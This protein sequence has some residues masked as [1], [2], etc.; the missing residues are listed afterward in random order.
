MEFVHLLQKNHQFTFCYIVESLTHCLTEV[1]RF[2]SW[3]SHRDGKLGIPDV[4]EDALVPVCLN[5]SFP[6]FNKKKIVQIDA[7]CDHSCVVTS[8]Y[9]FSLIRYRRRVLLAS[10]KSYGFHIFL[11]FS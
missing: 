7:G 10:I 2:F 4:K 11:H 8:K 6:L 9:P 5:E 1:V 3:G